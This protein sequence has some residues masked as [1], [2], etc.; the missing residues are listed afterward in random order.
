MAL[1][2]TPGWCRGHRWVS[3]GQELI[4]IVQPARQ[5]QQAAVT[6]V[7]V[8]QH[9][10]TCRATH[11][12]ILPQKHQDAHRNAFTVR[13]SARHVMVPDGRKRQ[14][15]RDDAQMNKRTSTVLYHTVLQMNKQLRASARVNE[16]APTEECLIV[17][18][19]Q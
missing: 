6:P 18:A 13:L 2:L 19:K 1:Q 5:L 17:L 11:Q 12:V 4:V 14:A 16:H 9:A 7:V 3:R 8:H 15:S 10:C